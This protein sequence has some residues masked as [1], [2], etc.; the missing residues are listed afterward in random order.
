M[1][2]SNERHPLEIPATDRRFR[3]VANFE[4]HRRDAEYYARARALFDRY[5]PMIGEHLHRAPISA[6]DELLMTANAP[7]NEAK[8]QMAEKAWEQVFKDIVG[9]LESP[10]PPV[11]VGPVVTTGDLIKEFERRKL[12][13]SEMPN[14]RTFPTELYALGAR[15]VSPEK[16]R[17][18][19]AFP[20]EKAGRI[21]RIARIWTDQHGV[22]WNL[23]TA[24]QTRLAKLYTDRQMPPFTDLK[25]VDGEEP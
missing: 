21:W 6:D 14:T 15:P 18:D 23:E 7:E 13:L 2:Y 25:V 24:S 8:A 1:I 4:A 5:W 11:D 20:V 16:K 12:P 19:R 17:P 3:V 22:E 10:H 9:E